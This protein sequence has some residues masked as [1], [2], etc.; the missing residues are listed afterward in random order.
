[1]KFKWLGPEGY[2]VGDAGGEGI[3][4]SRLADLAL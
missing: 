3:R 1:M 4:M 2:Y